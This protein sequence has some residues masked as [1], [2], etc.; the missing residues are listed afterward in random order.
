MAEAIEQHG[1][2]SDF[3]PGTLV[4]QSIGVQSLHIDHEI[5]LYDALRNQ[6]YRLNSFGADIWN[7][8]T[9]GRTVAVIQARF[10]N[11]GNE[12]LIAFLSGLYHRG[13]IGTHSSGGCT[14]DTEQSGEDD[15]GQH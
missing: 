10:P 5:V 4:Q 2:N 9:Q 13:L 6:S 12:D 3:H 7:F 8:L 14:T 1:G 15:Y 11:I